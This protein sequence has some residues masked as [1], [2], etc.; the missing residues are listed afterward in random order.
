[1][2]YDHGRRR[3]IVIRSLFFTFCFYTYSREDWFINAANQ[4]GRFGGDFEDFLAIFCSEVLLHDANLYMRIMSA[5]R[6]HH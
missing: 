3:G 1:M 6:D 2:D 4:A 5:I